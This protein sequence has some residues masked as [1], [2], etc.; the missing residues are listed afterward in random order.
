MDSS[1]VNLEMKREIIEQAINSIM[2]NYPSSADTIVSSAFDI[3]DPYSM[4]SLFDKSVHLVTRNRKVQTEPL[5]LNFI[6]KDPRDND[7]FETLKE[8]SYLN[9]YLLIVC[10]SL[11]KR[12]LDVDKANLETITF[13]SLL[14]YEALYV[15]G[16]TH[17]SEIVVRPMQKLSQCTVCENELK[18]YKKDTPRLALVD[19]IVCRTCGADIA[20]PFS[21]LLG[22]IKISFDEVET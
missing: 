5:N 8:I 6:F 9:L 15:K 3:S 1:R 17:L 4:A 18:F 16:K 2:I 13:R 7:S 11:Y 21:W 19:R 12:V 22:K 20:F 10:A 14:I